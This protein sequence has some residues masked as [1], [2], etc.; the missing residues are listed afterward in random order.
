M[1]KFILGIKLIKFFMETPL[2]SPAQKAPNRILRSIVAI[3][4]AVVVL[5]GAGGVYYYM[6]QQNP[7]EQKDTAPSDPPALKMSTLQGKS[8]ET[9][10]FVFDATDVLSAPADSQFATAKKG[11]NFFY[12]TTEKSVQELIAHV[13][14]VAGMKLLFAFYSPGETDRPACYYVYPVGPYQSTCLISDITTFK[15][16]AYRGFALIANQD[17]DYVKSSASSAAW[18]I[19]SSTEPAGSFNLA[20]KDNESGWVLVPMADLNKLTGTDPEKMNKMVSP[21]KVRLEK[22]YPQNGTASFTPQAVALD[23][24]QQ[25]P[26]NYSMVWVKMKQQ[27]AVTTT[28]S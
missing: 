5:G 14:P 3:V 16:P 27:P 10:F 12:S 24:F 20:L 17:F 25:I 19:K 2:Q 1:V 11:V 8:V 22:L 9:G 15:I 28:A 23:S 4:A 21:Y 6:S 26:G 7:Q 18:G 13:K